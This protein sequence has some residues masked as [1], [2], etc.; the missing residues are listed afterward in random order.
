MASNVSSVVSFVLENLEIHNRTYTTKADSLS[1]ADIATLKKIILEYNG[2]SCAKSVFGKSYFQKMSV[3]RGTPAFA[4]PHLWLLTAGI[5]LDDL[6]S[7]LGKCQSQYKATLSSVFGT[8]VA[9]DIE[10]DARDVPWFGGPAGVANRHELTTE[11][12]RAVHRILCVLSKLFPI[13]QCPM[14]PDLVA[15]LLYYLPEP[16]ILGVIS[17]MMKRGSHYFFIGYNERNHVCART[18]VDLISEHH[19]R[20]SRTMDSVGPTKILKPETFNEMSVWLSTF[21]STVFPYDSV[22]RVVDAYLLEGRKVL[23]RVAT[24]LVVHFQKIITDPIETELGCSASNACA[25]AAKIIERGFKFGMKR[26]I[27]NATMASHAR[28]DDLVSEDMSSSQENRKRSEN[29]MATTFHQPKTLTKGKTITEDTLLLDKEGSMNLM[30][31]FPSVEAKKDFQLLYSTQ[32]DGYNLNNLLEAYKKH[33]GAVVLIVQ[34]LCAPSSN[35]KDDLVGIFTPRSWF[36]GMLDFA[37]LCAYSDAFAFKLKPKFEFYPLNLKVSRSLDI[38]TNHDDILG[39]MSMHCHTIVQ[40]AQKIIQRTESSSLTYASVK[41]KL[42]NMFSEKIFEQN[43]AYV[44]LLLTLAD[45]P[46]SAGTAHSEAMDMLSTLYKQSR[47]QR[48]VGSCNAEGLIFG[49]D[50]EKGMHMALRLDKTLE[51][52]QS[53]SSDVFGNPPLVEAYG[54]NEWKV[55]NVELYG[56]V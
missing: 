7:S 47:T 12:E 39:F 38:T 46:L 48:I 41:G 34:P 17:S 4:R 22:L 18:T 56:L 1:K 26:T 5:D 19:K 52:A 31:E 10:I 32:C 14:L 21:F 3:R 25:T 42:I 43:K 16:F 27:L 36:P 6:E 44:T 11:G 45:P 13:S 20:G 8:H 15:I 33:R 2:T 40:E 50:L 37:S 55:K 9:K 30:R 24:A 51:Y 35:L 54:N 28:T 23:F 49:S 29:R 53:C